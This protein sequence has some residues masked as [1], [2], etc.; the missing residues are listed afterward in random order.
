MKRQN[1]SEISAGL[2]SKNDRYD[3]GALDHV[4]TLQ[5]YAARMVQRVLGYFDITRHQ[6]QA[7]SLDLFI[8]SPVRDHFLLRLPVSILAIT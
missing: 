2:N 8:S 4:V 3:D 6:M 7:R 5:V 1:V